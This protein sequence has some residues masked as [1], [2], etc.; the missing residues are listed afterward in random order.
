MWPS[1]LVGTVLK[2]ASGSV[3][4]SGVTKVTANEIRVYTIHIISG[5]TAGQVKLYNGTDIN[6]N[7]FAH[8]TCPVVSSGNTFDFGTNGLLFPNGCYALLDSN[9]TSVTFM[10]YG[11]GDYGAS[12]SSSSSSCRSSSSSSSSCSSSSSSSCSSSS[13]S[14]CSSSS[15]SSC[16]SSSSSSANP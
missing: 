8:A 1:G 9:V 14:S 5:A 12:S 2:T 15:S 6:G 11:E 3:P 13:S 10:F 16:R 4:I 7:L